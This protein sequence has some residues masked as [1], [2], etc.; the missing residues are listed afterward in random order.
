M[1]LDNPL[2]NV[3]LLFDL[4]EKN[5]GGYLCNL[6]RVVRKPVNANSGLKVLPYKDIFHCLCF[7]WLLDYTNSKQKA[8]Q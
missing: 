3:G 1:F 4:T 2:Y 8:T 6:G 7:V 5:F